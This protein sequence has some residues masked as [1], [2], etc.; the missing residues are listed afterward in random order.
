M[1]KSKKV[2][3]YAGKVHTNKTLS[4][5][6]KLSFGT[7]DDILINGA[8]SITPPNEIDVTGL[9]AGNVY[10][11]K[12][13]NRSTIIVCP[14]RFID[15]VAGVIFN[16]TNGTCTGSMRISYLLRSGAVVFTNVTMTRNQFDKL[17]FTQVAIDFIKPLDMTALCRFVGATTQPMRY[18]ESNP[19]LKLKTFTFNKNIQD[20]ASAG[21]NEFC[22][23]FSQVVEEEG[24]VGTYKEVAAGMSPT[25]LKKLIKG[26]S[27]LSDMLAV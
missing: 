6:L 19:F 20:A 7:L 4:D 25:E 15:N 11:L 27:K 2:I 5:L 18:T 8:M 23:D 14:T 21:V 12:G 9:V 10:S 13:S 24:V 3:S 17:T 22:S 26:L 16:S 1:T